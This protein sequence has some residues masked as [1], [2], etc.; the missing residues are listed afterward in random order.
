MIGKITAHMKEATEI[1]EIG[2][3]EN[4]L[5]IKDAEDAQT[6]LANA[7]AVLKDFYK[8]SGGMKKE[9][10]EFLQAGAPVDLPETPST[11]DSSY[12]SVAD[13]AAQPGG[14]VTVLEKVSAD[15]AQM[16]AETKA[17]EEADQEEFEDDM[18]ACK[19][20]MAG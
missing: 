10:W 1:R 3:K 14:I 17:Q 11:W 6:A 4:K 16:E 19:I 7:I 20:E 5:A 13:P 15:F 9:S 8:N 18:K 2:K 12:T